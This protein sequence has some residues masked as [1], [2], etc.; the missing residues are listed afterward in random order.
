MHEVRRQR[1]NTE[2]SRKAFIQRPFLFL[3]MDVLDDGS[4][5]LPI[6]LV[7]SQNIGGKTVRVR[8]DRI[9]EIK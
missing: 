9:Q 7:N 2:K 6:N 5:L 1:V 8:D 3:Q 4:A